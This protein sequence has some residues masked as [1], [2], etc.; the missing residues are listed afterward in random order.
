MDSLDV[1]S[2]TPEGSGTPPDGDAR[3]VGLVV[4]GMH[5]SGTSAWARALG[6]LGYRLPVNTMGASEGN[7]TGHWESAEMA[8]LTDAIFADQR[9]S[10]F[11]WGLMRLERMRARDRRDT[12]DDIGARLAMEFPGGADFVLKDPRLCRVAPLLLEAMRADGIDPRVVIPVRNPLE[13]MRS[14]GKRD[15]FSQ[16]YS[17]L[18]WL[19]YVL[20]A[21]L[22]SRDVPRVI[23]TY[24]GLL[25]APVR[26]L[27]HVVEA[28]GLR[29]SRSAE[30]ARDRLSEFLDP[31]LRH[32]ARTLDDVR[33]DA[34]T[35]G[36]VARA[37]E[38]MLKLAKHP[39]DREALAELDAVRGEFDS[40]TPIMER[41]VNTAFEELQAR[42]DTSSQL[43]AETA[44][45]ETLN[46][47][48]Q[49][50]QARIPA[51]EAEAKDATVKLVRSLES[52][53]EAAHELSRLREGLGASEAALAEARR[54]ADTAQV[55][56]AQFEAAGSEEAAQ[57]RLANQASQNE[58]VHLRE[59]LKRE[60][61][62]VLKP[63]A[64]RLRS[65]VGTA[66]RLVLPD[67]W[68]NR[69]AFM[70]PTSEQREIL[71][72]RRIGQT[73]GP[74]TLP[75]E[76]STDN[77]TTRPD[78]FVFAIIGWHFRTQRPQHI[79]RELA[80]R[81]HRVFYFE[82]DP[83]ATAGGEMERVHP[84]L[85][86][87]K[88]GHQGVP[89][90]PAYTGTPTPAQERAWLQAFYGFCDAHGATRF[91]HAIVQ[92]PFWWQLVRLLPPEFRTVYDC[93]D[94]IA[95]FENST[96]ELIAQEHRFLEEVDTLVVSGQTLFDKYRNYEPVRIIRNATQVA[97]FRDP[98][99]SALAPE[100]RAGSL[101]PAARIKVGYVGAIA[102]WFDA[103]MLEEVA[104][105]RPDVEF[106]LCGQVSAEGPKRLA[107]LANVKFYG[108]I[109]YAQV[110]AFL[111]QM[112]VL[113]IPFRIIP[114]I[115][116]CDPVKFYEY[117]M[118]G[119]PCVTTH[120]PELERVGDL[121]FFAEG[122]PEF[123]AQI[124]A[125]YARRDDAGFIARLRDFAEANS[126]AERGAAMDEVLEN[127]PKVSVVILSYGDPALTNATLKSLVE[128]GGEYPNLEILVV[129]NGSPPEALRAIGD[130]AGRFEHVRIIEN[131][132]NLGFA[133]GN[134]VGL[135]AAT[136]E[137]VLLLNNDTYV[138]PGAVWAMVA[139]LREHA[140]IGAVG[141][142]TNN[143]GNE[144]R[145]E[146]GYTDMNEMK[147]AARTLLTGHRGRHFD[148]RVVAYFAVMFRRADLARF[149]LLSEDYG[150]GMFEDD[151]H[152]AE[153]KKAG[154][155]TVVAEDAFVHHH[156]S[157]T[158]GQMDGGE[159]QALFDRNK[160]TFEAKWGPWVAHRYRESRPDGELQFPNSELG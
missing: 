72:M 105:S 160:A 117:S 13:V 45:A 98:D 23:C 59:L 85:I 126:W 61:R 93:M 64:R 60:Q 25:E 83:P 54:E 78:V 48:L 102:D 139:H 120:L 127:V 51:L 104:T 150:R 107:K 114:I 119:K 84:N 29:P 55:R 2:Q 71:R 124:D 81:G 91:K 153:I 157:A 97:H 42:E 92:H 112:D 20:D 151:D 80:E 21:E 47:Q 37:Y 41:M 146:I 49:L 125:A 34:V 11:S 62:T 88:L 46:Q 27:E 115:R 131:G 86:R 136:G 53:R 132:E 128:D 10:W 50:A 99:M 158:F 7:A 121:A 52:G 32:H 129:D 67:G 57:L 65:L 17:A 152:C 12:V 79:A 22:A 31:A 14:L 38:A 148:T 66:L 111:S 18:L 1:D 63:A 58:I 82:M 26:S 106:H 108:E 135:E 33:I 19:R 4:L 96:P 140:D 76:K 142:L 6:L 89:H 87:V 44:R 159:R 144:A 74:G 36:W 90:I 30:A 69:L 77:A 70:A 68:V 154:L 95:G 103:A 15:G 101:T 94:D 138:A 39:D 155:R 134:N 122:A 113:M 5:R 24:E 8:E 145:V 16:P 110:P 73:A 75:S 35:R 118:L 56:L 130:Y 43:Q 100:F 156:L 137:Y 109:P 133:R 9:Q 149:G 143:I 141:P 116:A 123:A 40:A 147:R 28:L 3:R